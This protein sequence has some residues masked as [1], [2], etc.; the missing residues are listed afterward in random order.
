MPEDRV[1]FFWS[2]APG[3]RSLVLGVKFRCAKFRPILTRGP[4]PTRPYHTLLPR[5]VC[6]RCR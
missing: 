1:A 3:K 6:S 5:K 2:P 4:W